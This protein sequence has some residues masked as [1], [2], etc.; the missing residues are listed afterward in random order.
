[1]QVNVYVPRQAE[2][3]P[4]RL[5]LLPTCSEVNVAHWITENWRFYETLDSA[6]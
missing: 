6:S 4:E 2:E 1:M 3:L 5:L